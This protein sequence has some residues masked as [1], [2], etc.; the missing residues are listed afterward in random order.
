M[1]NK[2]RQTV[3]VNSKEIVI[4]HTSFSLVVDNDCSIW[5]EDNYGTEQ[6]VIAYLTNDEIKALIKF[7]QERVV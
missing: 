5:I 3:F 2:S 4:K 6:N 7:L 1:I